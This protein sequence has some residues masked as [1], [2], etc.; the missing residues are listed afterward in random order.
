LAIVLYMSK[1]TPHA[2]KERHVHRDRDFVNEIY[3]RWTHVSECVAEGAPPQC[4]CNP[5]KPCSGRTAL[6]KMKAKA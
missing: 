5:D 4:E 3:D 6:K 2:F 1:D